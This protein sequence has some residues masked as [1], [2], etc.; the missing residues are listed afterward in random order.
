M[1]LGIPGQIVEISDAARSRAR[2][3]VEGVLHEVSLAMLELDPCDAARA[4][5]WVVVH[6]GFAMNRIDQCE[7][8]EMLDDRK[9]L[10]AMYAHELT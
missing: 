6:L 10:L 4:G 3:D 8:V 5:D 2:V 1:C 7:A 9:A